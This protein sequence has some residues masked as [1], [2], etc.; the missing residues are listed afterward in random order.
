MLSALALA[1][2]SS[3]WASAASRSAAAA[4]W[5]EVFWV[6]TAA[7]ADFLPFVRS[8]RMLAAWA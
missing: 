1:V 8:R 5:S 6:F 2:A 7:F 3:R 4:F